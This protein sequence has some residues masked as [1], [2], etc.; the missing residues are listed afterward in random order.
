MAAGLPLRVTTT[1]SSRSAMPVTNSDKR[2][3]TSEMGKV[4]GIEI[5]TTRR[6]FPPAGLALVRLGAPFPE[7]PARP[8]RAFGER[9]EFRPGDLG[10]SPPRPP[11]AVGSAHDVLA[12]QELRATQQALGDDPG[13][14]AAG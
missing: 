10:A 8:T 9:L 1:S 2:A 13:M 4:L 5:L 14:L 7:S 3:L 6:F 11:A 12:A